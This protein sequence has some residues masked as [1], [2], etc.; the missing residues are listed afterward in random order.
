MAVAGVAGFAI[1]YDVIGFRP[2][3]SGVTER[4]PMCG[5]SRVTRRLGRLSSGCPLANRSSGQQHASGDRP[6][7]VGDDSDVML[8][9]L[10]LYGLS[11]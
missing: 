3:A 11:P 7:A 9:D 10:T 1:S 6:T 5:P 2:E 8:L 4:G